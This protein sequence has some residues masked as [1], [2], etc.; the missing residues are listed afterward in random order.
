MKLIAFNE[1][2]TG[3]RVCEVVCAFHHKKVFSRK[4]SS[5]RVK[6]I[7]RRG[8]FE[9]IIY[10]VNKDGHLAC[11]LCRGEKEPLCVRF[12]STKALTIEG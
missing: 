10:S 3:C 6:R 11:D 1:K 8:E 5:V 2:C 4:I 7:E 9:I 12:C